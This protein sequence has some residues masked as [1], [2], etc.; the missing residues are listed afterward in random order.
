MSFNYIRED[1]W[2]CFF[3]SSQ[4]EPSTDCSDGAGDDC[5]ILHAIQSFFWM[6][7]DDQYN[8]ESIEC[9]LSSAS[10]SDNS[11][12]SAPNAIS[13]SVMISFCCP[14]VLDMSKLS[15]LSRSSTLQYML[16]ISCNFVRGLDQ[17][18]LQVPSYKFNFSQNSRPCIII[19][20]HLLK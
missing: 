17:K 8:L 18:T 3:Q 7:I 9:C 14:R 10:N 19:N 11:L 1:G 15:C 6:C 13:V 5:V 16:R 12:L 4:A 20:D 2:D